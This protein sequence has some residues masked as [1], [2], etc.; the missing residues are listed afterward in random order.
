MFS[1]SSNNN[2]KS[3]DLLEFS[4]IISSSPPNRDRFTFNNQLKPVDEYFKSNKIDDCPNWFETMKKHIP[5]DRY[6]QIDLLK[7]FQE[8]IIIN[9]KLEKAYLST[10]VISKATIFGR[11]AILTF[12]AHKHNNDFLIFIENY[13]HSK[14]PKSNTTEI[15]AILK[16]QAEKLFISGPS[17]DNF[18]DYEF[19]DKN[20]FEDEMS[21]FPFI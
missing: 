9:N 10:R 19:L 5:M 21:F 16:E 17:I 7:E 1:K 13:I 15:I 11:N 3:K 14:Y 18:A 6:A 2:Y 20:N 4:N 12:L 8:F